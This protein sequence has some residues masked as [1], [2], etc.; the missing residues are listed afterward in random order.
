MVITLIGYRGT[1]KSSVAPA[2]AGRLGWTSID[3]DV[4]IEARAGCSIAEIFRTE[5]EPGFRSREREVLREL[6]GRPKLILA[7]GGGAILAP[8]TR[9]AMREAGPVVWLEASVETILD[10]MNQDA[11]TASRRP[12]LTAEADPR[13]EI[14][15]L[16]A[17]R[18][19]LYRET[20]T[21]SVPTDGR[22]VHEIVEAIL[23]TIP[24]QAAG[25][26]A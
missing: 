24:A 22:P 8:E 7:A 25:G 1:G 14:L 15:R 19:P 13:A 12:A 5:G 10:R 17:I 2:L 20:A 16:L 23:T 21:L 6:L 11:T 4:E 26:A 9:A 3:A 18:T